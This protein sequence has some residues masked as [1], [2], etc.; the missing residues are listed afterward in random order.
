M[1]VMTFDLSSKCIGVTFAQIKRNEISY[2]KTLAVIPEKINARDLG[3]RTKGVTE[4]GLFK[5]GELKTSKKEQVNRLRVFKNTR[6]NLLLTNIGKQIGRFLLEIKP[7]II[8]IERNKS[9]KGILTTKLLAEIAGG[10]YF[11]AGAFQIPIY[12]WDESEIRAKIRKDIPHIDLAH[13]VTGQT[14]LDTKWEIQCR[15]R[16]FFEKHYPG[17]FDFSNMTLDES[18]SLAVFYY[19]YTTIISNKEE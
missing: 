8:A 18:D 16:V 17:M 19:L 13:P 1:I 7:N 4:K 2:G 11:W 10:L 12:D 5:L 9:F 15:L 6:H 14:A 3:F